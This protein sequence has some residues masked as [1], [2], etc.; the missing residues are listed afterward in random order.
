M[1]VYTERYREIYDIFNILYT[2]IYYNIGC[3]SPM[4]HY[5]YPHFYNIYCNL[6]IYIHVYYTA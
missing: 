4:L 3:K 1:Y 6:Y 5:F 2:H